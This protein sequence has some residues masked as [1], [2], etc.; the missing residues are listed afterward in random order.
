MQ[1]SQILL[2]T[3]ISFIL[4]GCG[5]TAVHQQNSKLN[6][7]I[8]AISL[9]IQHPVGMQ[10]RLGQIL[11][12]SLSE[13]LNPARIVS[14]AKYKLALEYSEGQGT[15]ASNTD[16][17][18]VRKNVEVMVNYHLIDTASGVVIASG[19]QKMVDSYDTVTSQYANYVAYKKL[20]ER[21]A[22][23]LAAQIKHAISIN[24]LSNAPN[25]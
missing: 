13:A 6:E 20:L 23:N 25:N 18:I 2:L 15:S 8:A 3:I 19:Q 4:T 5:F 12:K 22:I 24:L 9:E 16:G 1:H 21:N 11:E 14:N 17:T 7:D 10:T